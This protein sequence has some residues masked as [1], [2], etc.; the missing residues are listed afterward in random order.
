[1][2]K[3]LIERALLIFRENA[4][5]SQ[6]GEIVEREVNRILE[7]IKRAKTE[8]ELMEVLKDLKKEVEFY[9]R[10]KKMINDVALVRIYIYTLIQIALQK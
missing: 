9:K 1:M 10:N 8:E 4:K 6:Y 2:E 3:I 5:N 7:K